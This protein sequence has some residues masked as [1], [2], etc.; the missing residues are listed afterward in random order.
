MLDKVTIAAVGISKSY[1]LTKSGSR[2]GLTR[3]KNR[4]RIDALKQLSFVAYA[5]ESIGVLGRNGSGK[6]TLLQLLA[7]QE[8]PSAG[9]I[10][11]SANPTLVSVGS[12]L[13]KHLTGSQNIK[14]GLLAQGMGPAAVDSEVPEVLEWAGLESAAHRPLGSYSAGMRARLK[15]AITTASPKEILLVDEAL[16][17]GDSS[18]SERAK[19]RM[20]EFLNE[21]GTVMIVSHSAP[22][23]R[24]YCNRALWLHDGELLADGEATAISNAYESWSRASARGDVELERKIICQA[25]ESRRIQRVVFDSD[26]ANFLESRTNYGDP[27]T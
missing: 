7:G 16:A 20:E 17:T 4:T 3:K 22:Q 1:L 23:I 18:F 5:G 13:Q 24:K 9:E 15:F 27:V 2:I 12:I 10:L 8:S 25:R 6:S 19:R 11:V 26:A 14:L 21:A